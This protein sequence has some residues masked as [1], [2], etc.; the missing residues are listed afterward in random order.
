MSLFIPFSLLAQQHKTTSEMMP[1]T[2]VSSIINDSVKKAFDI[3]SFIFRVIKY[4]DA[5]GEYFCVLTESNDSFSTTDEGKPD[6]AHYRIRAIN[7]RS[8]NGKMTKAWEINDFILKNNAEI[9][10]WW[11]T[12]F[13]L[14]QDYDDDGL[15][16]PIIVYGSHSTDEINGN[17]IKFII[18]YKGQK[19]AIR[20]Q[21]SDLDE[22]RGTE[23]D[24]AFHSLPQKLK[25]A[26]RAKMELMNKD[27]LAIFEKTSF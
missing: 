4:T 17:R 13:C 2:R 5:S 10:I 9:S 8:D 16:E 21:D 25:D 27:G 7:L 24:K 3:N 14:F 26:V 18:Y 23:V 19:I 20:H 22:G 11:W 12:R 1:S 15:I 6:T